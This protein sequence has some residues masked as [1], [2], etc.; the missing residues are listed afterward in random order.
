MVASTAGTLDAWAVILAGGDGVRLRPL[1]RRLAGDDRPKQFCAIAGHESL[2]TRTRRRVALSVAEERTLLVLTR[3]HEVF[4]RT[5]LSGVAPG[6]LI[7]QPTNRGTAPAILYA[8]V[9]VAVRSPGALVAI[10]PSDHY[11]SDDRVFMAHVDAAF[12]LARRRPDLLILLGIEG[13]R[14]EPEYGWIVPGERLAGP[15]PAPLYRVAAF[16]EKPP[17]AE[18]RALWEQ[19]ALQNSFVLVGAVSAF[20]AAVRERLPQLAAA[21]ARLAL[22]LDTPREADA[23]RAAYDALPSCS[24]SRDVLEAAPPGLAVL[25][26]R[27]VVWSDWGTPERVL[28]TLTRLRV[29]PAWAGDLASLPSA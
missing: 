14:P 23:V 9:R 25:P 4:F 5:E 16:R 26:V 18:A 11:V 24:F 8:V 13:E 2:L 15:D 12:V 10:L 27:G 1:T 29:T 17:A 21:F 7:V 3:T 19:G 22:V 28:A 6:R 20:L